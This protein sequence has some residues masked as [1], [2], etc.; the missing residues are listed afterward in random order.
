MQEELTD[1]ELE[2]E[3]IEFLIEQMEARDELGL[4]EQR[5]QKEQW[6]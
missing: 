1:E 2:L 4:E 6:R 5:N 3:S